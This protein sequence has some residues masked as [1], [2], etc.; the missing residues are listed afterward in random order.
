MKQS[1]MDKRCFELRQIIICRPCIESIP[2]TQ[3]DIDAHIQKP[4][5]INKTKHYLSELG[6]TRSTLVEAPNIVMSTFYDT[7]TPFMDANEVSGNKEVA[8][9]QDGHE[10]DYQNNQQSDS[11]LKPLSPLSFSCLIKKVLNEEEGIPITSPLYANESLENILSSD[12]FRAISTTFD[13]DHLKPSKVQM[14]LLNNT[15]EPHDN[16]LVA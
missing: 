6:G 15:L 4:T 8:H 12:L 10:G 9:E 1:I 3:E 11:S 2:Y 5:H 13:F 16:L 7:I 14:T